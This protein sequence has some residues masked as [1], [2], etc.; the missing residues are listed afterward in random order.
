[1]FD[2]VK[3]LFAALRGHP[4]LDLTATNELEIQRE[5]NN[6]ATEAANDRASFNAKTDELTNLNT[7]ASRLDLESKTLAKDIAH[8]QEITQSLNTYLE[9]FKDNHLEDFNIL[10]ASDSTDSN[11][12]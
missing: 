1:M 5:I 10:G 2:E 11:I 9:D 4:I 12:N 3:T 6:I 8:N 7:V